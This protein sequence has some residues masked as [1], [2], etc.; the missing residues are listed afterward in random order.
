[1][2]METAKTGGV[3]HSLALQKRESMEVRGVTDVISFDEQEAVL[4]TVCG[5]LAIEGTDLR[6]HVLSIESGVVTMEG[7]INS[8]VY[9][10]TENDGKDGKNG[11]FG[12]IFR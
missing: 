6:V 5:R 2:S 4:D 10:D 12:R 9:Y 7:K 1:M 11:F 8:V 3:E